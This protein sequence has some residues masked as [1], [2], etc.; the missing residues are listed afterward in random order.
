MS[1][2]V[3]SPASAATGQSDQSTKISYEVKIYEVADGDTLWAVA[4]RFNVT[5]E[6]VMWANNI[7]NGDSLSIGQKL[8]IPPVSGALHTIQE[9]DTAIDIAK[10]YGIDVQALLAFEGNSIASP[11]KLSLG[12]RLV[13]PGGIKPQEQQEPKLM[14]ASAAAPPPSAPAP[15]PALSV[16]PPPPPPPAPAPASAPAPARKSGLALQWPAYGPTSTYGGHK[17]TDIGAAYGAAVVAAEA[18]VVTQAGELYDGY[19]IHVIIDH[20]NGFTTL[21]AHLSQALVRPGQAVGRGAQI[22]NVGLTGR[23]TGAHLHFEV[24]YGGVPRYALDYLP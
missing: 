23:T 5:A 19:G 17:G 7:K 3:A 14:V 15:A 13:I 16:A 20:G 24:R 8:D 9:G 1:T 4:G 18:G 12:Q 11:D 21:Y 6:T 10:R 22:G 2:S